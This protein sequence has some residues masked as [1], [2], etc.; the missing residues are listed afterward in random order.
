MSATVPD[1]DARFDENYLYFYGTTQSAEGNEGEADLIVH[2][3]GITPSMEI[4]DLPCGFGRIANRL[5]ARGSRVTGLDASP[6]YLQRARQDAAGLGVP[7]E[8]VAGDMR[9]LPWTD[10]FD[11]IVIWYISFGYFDDEANRRVLA[12]CRQALRPGGRLLIDHWNLPNVLRGAQP[13]MGIASQVGDD[14]MIFSSRYNPLS[15][16]NESERLLIRAGKV[17]RHPFSIR[18]FTYAELRDWLTQ[19]GFSRVDA[20]SR[21]GGPLTLESSGM[22][23]VAHA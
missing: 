21:E 12:G 16:R 8:Y 17:S 20:H 3:L 13:S 15:G 11:R 7:V 10:R 1:L 4:L 5:A 19:A 2:L 23:V 14:M 22:I 6:L 9:H 18:C